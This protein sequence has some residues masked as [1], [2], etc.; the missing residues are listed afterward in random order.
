MKEYTHFRG[1]LI[2]DLTEEEKIMAHKMSIYYM[3]LEKR[4]KKYYKDKA[5]KFLYE[6]N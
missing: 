6:R 5:K 3:E 2:K 4:D 1:K